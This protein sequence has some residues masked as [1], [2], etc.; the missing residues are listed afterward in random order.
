LMA[1]GLMILPA[2][3]ARCWTR[4]ITAYLALT[5]AIA[6]FSCWAGLIIS[7]YAPSVPSGPAIVVVAGA[8]FV[9]SM[10]FGGQGARAWTP[11]PTPSPNPKRR[12]Q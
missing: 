10:F 2:T 6:L 8:A 5:F 7:F 3:A 9:F 12:L 11:S 4:T 1:V